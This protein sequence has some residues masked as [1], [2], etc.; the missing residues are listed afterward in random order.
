MAVI[1]FK[2]TVIRIRTEGS[3]WDENLTEMR[4]EMKCRIDE[5]TKLVRSLSGSNGAQN[6]TA[7]E[8]VSTANIYFDK[9]ADI[10]LTDMLEF[11]NEL[12]ITRKLPPLTIEIKRSISGKPILTVVSV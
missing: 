6:T 11:T 8:V 4:S 10:Q 12:G 9:L 7:S 2:Q 3:E 1:P 5:G